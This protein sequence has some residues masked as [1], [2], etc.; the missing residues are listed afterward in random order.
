MYIKTEAIILKT[1]DFSESSIIA[2]IFTRSSGKIHALAKGGRRIKGPFESALDLMARVLVTYI[3]KRG[4]VLDLLTEAKLIRRYRPDKD[5]FPG[6]YAGYYVIELL[7]AMTVEENPSPEVYDLAAETLD[8]LDAGDDVL[9]YLMRFEW[10]MLELTGAFPMLDQC[11]QCG[12]EMPEN[13][14]KTMTFAHLDGG[15]LCTRC[16]EGKQQLSLISTNLVECIGELVEMESHSLSKV[17]MNLAEKREMRKLLNLYI[18][19]MLGKRPKMFDYFKEMVK[20]DKDVQNE[21]NENHE[22]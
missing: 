3:A 20:R 5:N 8:R 14:E 11:V 16:R 1:V 13:S 10:Q 21:N 12:C 18:S 15:I 22:C 6:L 2:T 7:D 17:T 19:N 4:D 9:L